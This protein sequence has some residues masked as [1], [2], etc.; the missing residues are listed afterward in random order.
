MN[1]STQGMRASQ[2]HQRVM[3]R[4]A[5]E[6]G[7]DSAAVA[8]ARHDLALVRNYA[9]DLLK[10]I[11]P[12]LS[13][14][15]RRAAVSA[16]PEELVVHREL[17]RALILAR[18]PEDVA[19]HVSGC[20]LA[21]PVRRSLFVD[22]ADE[23]VAE[24]RSKQAIATMESMLRL[25]PHDDASRRALLKAEILMDKP[26]EAVERLKRSELSAADQA[27]VL[28]Q[29]AI[30][31]EGAGDSVRVLDCRRAAAELVP[32]DAALVYDLI[33]TLMRRESFEAAVAALDAETFKGADKV[34]ILREL[35]GEMDRTRQTANALKCRREIAI[36]A[37]S[38][39]TA[40]LEFIRTTMQNQGIDQAISELDTAVFQITDR[41]QVL[42]DLG[43][44]LD[45]AGKTDL[46]FR[47]K[48]EAFR[49]APDIG[50]VVYELALHLLNLKGSDGLRAYFARANGSGDHSVTVL[51][52]F[53]RFLMERGQ[54]D[55]A[56]QCSIFIYALSPA[57][58]DK[59]VE[60]FAESSK[61]WNVENEAG[62]MKRA[63]LST[64]QIAA[65]IARLSER[66]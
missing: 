49:R 47:C 3:L 65:V 61:N 37:A 56:R 52:A 4:R 7:D 60:R 48:E 19:T 41:V 10:E 46:A 64:E 66:P 53:E 30:E 13:L 28:R 58:V 26:E 27:T 17:M 16:A 5:L 20:G 32:H 43:G 55:L 9:N 1:A 24:N 50:G 57:D 29:L 8:I 6:A 2:L 15:A 31:F 35:G 54:S 36:R 42:R 12:Q 25:W 22:L 62:D 23:F 45:R 44:E 38:N 14:A 21:E 33:H 18:K 40:V 51:I 11:K 39:V 34:L 59:H 63:G